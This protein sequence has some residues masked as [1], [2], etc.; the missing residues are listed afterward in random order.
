M[1]APTH[2]T[3]D[4]EFKYDDGKY[5]EKYYEN[6]DIDSR[7]AEVM[8]RVEEESELATSSQQTREEYL[9]LFEKNVNARRD[10]R[11]PNQEELKMSREG[12]ILHMNEFLSRLKRCGLNCW[13]SEKGGMAKTLGLYVGHD[14]TAKCNHEYGMPHYVCYVQVPFMQEYEEL[15]FDRYN[16]PLGSKRRGWRTVLLKLIEQGILTVDKVNEIFGKPATGPV[17]RRYNEYLNFIARP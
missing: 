9:R 5:G 3:Y 11:F 2:K 16:I 10:S 1:I 6:L 12:Q 4:D 7:T 13:Y 14:K 8:R 15:H 17:S